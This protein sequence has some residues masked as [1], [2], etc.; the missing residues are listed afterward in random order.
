[1]LLLLLLLLL[2]LVAQDHLH[3]PG[4]APGEAVCVGV[5]DVGRVGHGWVGER[6]QWCWRGWGVCVSFG[7]GA[8][9]VA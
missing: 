4:G 3:L 8:G 6:V 2:L 1:M 5:D 7:D 9:L